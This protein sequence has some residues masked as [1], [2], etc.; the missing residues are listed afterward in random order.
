MWLGNIQDILRSGKTDLKHAICTRDDIMNQLMDYGVQPKMAFDT[1]EF[2][3]KGKAAAGKG[4]DLKPE[5]LEAMQKAN[6]PDWFIEACRK[7][8]YMFPKAHAVA[9]VT[10]ALRIAYFKIFYPAQYYT[11]FL[12]R[13][14]ESFNGATMVCSVE[15]LR[16]MQREIDNMEKDERE[17]SEPEYSLLESLIEMNLRGITLLPVNLYASDAERFLLVDDTHILPPLSALPGLGLTAAQNLAEAR[18]AGP[19]ISRDDMVRRK[20]GK[21]VVEILAAA[22]CIN[23]LPES[24]QV[25]L[26]E[27]GF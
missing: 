13:N 24:S 9:Y 18:S 3:R 27:M 21:S 23:D 14:A 11:C 22:G 26:F 17:R 19:F 1:M 25:S 12:M 4:G 2:V 6:T 8:E 10:M 15:Q 7:I 5:M 20:V 16:N